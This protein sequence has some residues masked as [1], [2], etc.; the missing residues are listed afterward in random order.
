MAGVGDE[1]EDFL[2]RRKPVF[3]SPDDMFEPPAELDRV[4][5]RQA[6][7]AIESERPLKV[8]H[9]PRW[10]A[11]V[12]LAA[13]LL[14]A[15]TIIL[16]TGMPPGQGPVPEVT[17]QNISE[18]VEMSDAAAP[19]APAPSAANNRAREDAA[20]G[21]ASSNTV[22]IDLTPPVMAKRESTNTTGLVSN[23]EAERH[24]APPPST[25]PM[26]ARTPSEST[27][28]ASADASAKASAIVA[29]P[30]ASTEIPAWRRD[31]LAWKA[32]IERL[33]N[34]G[35]IA[36]ADAELAEF[37]RQHRAYAVGPDR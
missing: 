3:R 32:E 36:R 10:A 24:A 21:D 18:R 11:P 25:A 27:A 19:M 31:P 1:F 15:V 8:F 2:K 22:T 35:H 37:N 4:V 28:G 5:L 30:S 26:V 34:A 9:G 14:L 6:R 29:A 17:V 12:A 23:E 16:Q 20:A 13:T 33:R 7:E